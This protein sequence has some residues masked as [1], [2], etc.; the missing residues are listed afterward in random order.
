MS[1]IKKAVVSTFDHSLSFKFASGKTVNIETSD[2]TDEICQKAL[3]HGLKQKLA[4]SYSGV[5]TD[6][7]VEAAFEA[8]LN[9]LLTGS[10]NAGRSSLGGIWVEALARAAG[11]SVE[12]AA[13]KWRELEEEA[14]KDLKKNAQIKQAKAEIEL[15]R[16]KV[17]A[18]GTTLDLSDLA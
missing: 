13:Q 4:D 16:A 12:E 8:T 5:K 11:V 7:E 6:H 14:Q 15:E 3:I 2:L 18:K 17:K 10:W 1:S 9:S